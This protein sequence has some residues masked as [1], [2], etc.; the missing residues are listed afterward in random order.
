MSAASELFGTNIRAT[1]TTTAPNFVRGSVTIMALINAWL[2]P[3]VGL[4]S[5]SIYIGIAV[6]I[7]AFIANY[8]LEETFSKDLNYIEN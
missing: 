5:S 6:F 8:F 2:K 4:V 3:S 7:L 1:V